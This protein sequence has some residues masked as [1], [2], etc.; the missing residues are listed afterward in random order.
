MSRAQPRRGVPRAPEDRGVKERWVSLSVRGI[1]PPASIRWLL[2]VAGTLLLLAPRHALAGV[3]A[4]YVGVS[5][6][7]GAEPYDEVLRA[8][9]GNSPGTRTGDGKGVIYGRGRLAPLV[10]VEGSKVEN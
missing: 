4:D 9:R 7:D 3:P 2:L 1:G 8:L 10:C 6:P 5:I